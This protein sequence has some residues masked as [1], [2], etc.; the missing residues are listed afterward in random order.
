MIKCLHE[1]VDRFGEY[2]KNPLMQDAMPLIRISFKA[3]EG[4][5]RLRLTVGADFVEDEENAH[6]L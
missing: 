5:N 2:L 3:D 1:M 6:E 4:G